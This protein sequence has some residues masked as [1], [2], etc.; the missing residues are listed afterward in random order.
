MRI[1]VA[2]ALG[3]VVRGSVGTVGR[4][5][6]LGAGVAI[7]LAVAPPAQVG[8]AMVATDHV[9][10][11]RAGADVLAAGGNAADAAAAAA[12]SAS[13]VQPAGSGL[14]GGGFAL[15]V[16][17]GNDPFVLDFREV[18]P[19][20]ASSDMYV[21]PDGSVDEGASRV[22]GRAVAVVSEPVGL[23][24]LVRQHGRL[25]LRAVARPAIRQARQG[26]VVGPHLAASLS[27]TSYPSV[28]EVFSMGSRVAGRGDR[29]RRPR[30]A[31]TLRAWAAQNGRALHEG[32]GAQAI[33]AAVA[34]AGGVLTADDLASYETRS[35]EPLVGS[36]R[37][38][39][40][41]T[42]PPPSSGGVALLQLL[43][44]LESW[45]LPALGHNSS[46]YVHLLAEAMKHVYADRAHHLGDPDFVQVPVSRLLSS[47]RTHEITSAIEDARTYGVEHY[48]PLIAPP[49]DEGTQHI[50]VLDAE[51]FAL[52]LTTTINTPFGSGVMVP[53]WGVLLNNQ[54]DDFS[55]QPGA[56]NT[57]GLVGSEANA[58][59]AGKRPLSSMSPTTVL[60]AE[61]NPVLVIGAS[62]GSTIISAT[63]QV[64]LNVLDFGMDPQTAV[65]LPRMHHQWVP[66]K[67]WL[68]PEYPRDVVRALEAR[69]HEVTVRPG[70]SAVQV[71]HRTEETTAGGADPRKGGWPAAPGD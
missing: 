30:L 59:A 48:G 32:R 14:G 62:G 55:A 46:E 16:R 28:R 2:I 67:L 70:F 47:A 8:P 36:Y 20:A 10:A 26:F 65:S 58:I 24:D 33:E 64:L 50:S 37:G 45:D 34:D 1:V 63:L 19:A 13:V 29:I 11:S 44:V 31:R 57:Y 27:R 21:A 38:F 60:D 7:L 6:A 39:T 53:E 12:L 22:G 68:E 52:A 61:G 9:L 17:P 3:G 41:I 42:M 51:G 56:A 71:V 18:A 15:G 35:R 25:S 23:A 5:S 43:S 4:M 69:G 54:M 49:L 40:V 66:N